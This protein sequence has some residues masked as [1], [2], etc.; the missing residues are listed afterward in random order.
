MKSVRPLLRVTAAIAAVGLRGDGEKQ[1]AQMNGRYRELLEAA[2]DAMVVVNHGGEIVLLKP[3]GG[4]AV[5]I[6]P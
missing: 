1:L 2:P 3:S 4:E 5:R 6:S